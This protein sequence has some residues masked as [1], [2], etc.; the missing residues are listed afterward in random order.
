[1]VRIGGTKVVER[2]EASK[3]LRGKKQGKKEI[4]LRRLYGK[5]SSDRRGRSAVDGKTR[6][7][8]D[9]GKSCTSHKTK[10]KW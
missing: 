1:L 9:Q 2:D 3:D 4:G 6:T 8:T 10:G 7:K 5:V